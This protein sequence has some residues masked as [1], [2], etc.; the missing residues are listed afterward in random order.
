MFYDP[1][2]PANLTCH[3]HLSQH[4][5]VTWQGECVSSKP[6][7]TAGFQTFIQFSLMLHYYQL[8]VILPQIP[9]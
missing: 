6:S 8:L 2:E 4:T 3:P 1:K 7:L 9:P 5:L